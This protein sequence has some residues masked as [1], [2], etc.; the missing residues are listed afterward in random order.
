MA[1]ILSVHLKSIPEVIVVNDNDN[2]FTVQIAIEFH[3]LDIALQMEYV[4]H[5]FVYDI[6][7]N[8]DAPLVVPNWDE[9][10]VIPIP[11]GAFSSDELIGK[12]SK[13]LSA[14]K[15]VETLEIPMRLKLGKLSERSSRT[16]KKFEVF[17]TMTPAIGSA[18]KWSKPFE[19]RIEF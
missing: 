2:D 11:E 4:L 10:R 5:V 16:S 14:S 12:S 7:G 6:H 17:A 1:K 18:S 8:V 9:S 3:H 19:S 13:K 15:K